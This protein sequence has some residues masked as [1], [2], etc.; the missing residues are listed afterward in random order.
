[1]ASSL[2]FFFTNVTTL[3]LF[4]WFLPNFRAN[5]MDFVQAFSF[6]PFTFWFFKCS[7]CVIILY[8]PYVNGQLYSLLEFFC[9]LWK[10]YTVSYVSHEQNGE[11]VECGAHAYFIREIEPPRKMSI[12]LL[13]I[14]E[15]VATRFQMLEL[16]HHSLCH[17]NQEYILLHNESVTT[18]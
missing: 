12:E 15:H 2:R 1:M 17:Q 5:A 6:S 16:C 7:F 10:R 18:K 13:R 8:F 11:T 3:L 4:F 9:S 14:V